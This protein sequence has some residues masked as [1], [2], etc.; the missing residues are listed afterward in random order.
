MIKRLIFLL[1]FVTA[2]VF[3]QDIESTVNGLVQPLVDAGKNRGVSVGLFEIGNEYPKM[4]FYGKIAKEDPTKPNEYT[5]YEIGSITKTFTAM[6]MMMLARD[7]KM[8]VSDP[9][10]KFLPDSVTIHNFTSSEHIKIANLVTHTSG[11]PNM[12]TNLMADPKTDKKDPYK[13]YT[14]TDMYNFINNY[15]LERE[16]GTRYIYS[17]LGMGLLGH[18]ESRASGMSYEKVLHYYILDSLGMNWTGITLSSE[19]SKNL[20]KGYTEKGEPTG[21]WNYQALEGSGAIRSNLK[22]MLKYLAFNMGKTDTMHFKEALEMMQRR[23]FDTDMPGVYIGT[24]WNISETG[25]GKQV[26]WYNNN[27][28]GYTGYIAFMPETGSGVVVLSNQA[29]PVDQV[30]IEIMRYLNR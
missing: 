3:S 9:V 24:G 30:G 15:I 22:D 10:Q 29:T 28:G 18:L 16:P 6:M 19:M 21:N 27:M 12:P 4:F 11:L 20:A 1:I 25:D 5:V 23:R 13:N 2:S 14:T 7:G 26:I 17:D 8:Q